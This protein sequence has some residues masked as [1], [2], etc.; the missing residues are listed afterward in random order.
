MDNSTV[1]REL[2]ARARAMA[3]AGENLYRVRAYRRAAVA[4]FGLDRPAGE[5]PID[6]LRA[7]TGVGAS[8]AETIAEI[9]GTYA[10][11]PMRPSTGLAK[12]G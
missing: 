11:E 1:A 9:A 6:R 8:L 12:A 7:L 5:L 2:Q 4:V 10:T 3:A